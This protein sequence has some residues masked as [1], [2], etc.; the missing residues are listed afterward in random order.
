MSPRELRIIYWTAT[1]AFGVPQALSALLCLLDLPA[2]VPGIAALGYPVYFLKMLATAKLLGIATIVSGRFPVLKE[3]AYAG[4]T[5]EVIAAIFSHWSVSGTASVAA[6]PFAFLLVQLVS[7]W[8][9]T[10]IDHRSGVHGQARRRDR[11]VVRVSR[12]ATQG[13]D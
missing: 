5:F 8:S 4:F 7:Y 11:V 2:M 13:Y 3:W 6:L 10:R 1:L 9:W 12:Y